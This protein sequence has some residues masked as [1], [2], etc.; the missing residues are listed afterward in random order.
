MLERLIENWL[1][2]A[3]ERS[4]QS[5]FCQMLLNEGYT[6]IH[7]T[8]HSNVEF[9]KD[10]IALDPD[11][12]PCAFQLKGN[13]G[14]RL[15]LSQYR[16]EVAPQLREL[17][18]QP[19]QAP[20]VPSGVQHQ[21]FLV[22]NGE[23]EE[24]VQLA[25]SQENAANVRDGYPLRIVNLISRGQLLAWAMKLDTSLWPSDLVDA[26][27]ILEIL[28]SDGTGLFPI[29]KFHLL[30]TTLFHLNDD[31]VS[32]AQ[33]DRMLASGALFTSICLKTFSARSNSWAAITAWTM[34]AV[35]GCAC[36]EKFNL[37]S[38]SL[39]RQLALAEEFIVNELS[40]LISEAIASN[41]RLHAGS[42]VTDFI[43]FKWRKRLLIGI[44]AAFQ[45]WTTQVQKNASGIDGNAL[46]QFIMNERHELDAL[47][48]CEIP[49]VL[50][51]RMADIIYRG[52]DFEK[53]G[54]IATLCFQKPL[55]ACYYGIETV[56]RHELSATLEHFPPEFS[57]GE[58]KSMETSSSMMHQIFLLL[59]SMDQKEICKHLWPS[60]SRITHFM[61]SPRSKWAYAILR[62]EFGDNLQIAPPERGHWSELREQA[63]GAIGAVVPQTLAQKPLLLGLWTLIAPHRTLPEVL[64][65]LHRRAMVIA[66]EKS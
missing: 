20:S 42:L 10:I 65:F 51:A 17:V 11:G 56:L 48:D 2:S 8:R 12:M 54:E 14:G 40:S 63:N 32:S 44:A 39:N 37:T 45:L 38:D 1:D 55:P 34:F 58:I 46:W 36:C 35:Y 33:F 30:L 23:V 4:Y 62:T 21:S 41:G 26:R 22:T 5:A 60:Y 43:A 15:T 9:G 50:F 31:K 19:I 6:V 64:I 16:N 47:S 7:S 29:E 3:S 13:P 28:T 52:G 59:V 24:E 53:F 18:V 25:I 57:D 27:Y 61:F 66:E 49:A